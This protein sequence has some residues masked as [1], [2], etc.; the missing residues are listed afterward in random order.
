M[1][2]TEH[3][4]S[5][6]K[7]HPACWRCVQNG[8]KYIT[9]TKWDKSERAFRR[10]LRIAEYLKDRLGEGYVTNGLGYL[11]HCRGN[12]ADALAHFQDAF[13]I[14]TE[15]NDDAMCIAAIGN[16]ANIYLAQ[17]LYDEAIARYQQVIQLDKKIRGYSNQ[18]ISLLN[19][20]ACLI[21]QEKYS[22]A[23]T[24]LLEVLQRIKKSDSPEHADKAHYT[25]DALRLA[26]VHNNLAHIAFEQG[27]Y[28]RGNQYIKIAR[29]LIAEISNQ[30]EE[31]HALLLL[32]KYRKRGNRA[33][34]EE[35]LR[36][37]QEIESD[38]LTRQIHDALVM[39]HSRGKRWQ[40]AL[41][42]STQS[43][44]L[45]KK[46]FSPKANQRL[47][48]LRRKELQDALQT[49][50]KLREDAQRVAN[51]DSLTGLY[52]RRFIDSR[53]AQLFEEAQKNQTD[54][55]V[56][57]LDIDNFKQVN[58]NHSHAVGDTVLRHIAS[59]LSKGLRT[60]DLVGRYGGEEF[61]MILPHTSLVNAN[62]VCERIRQ[63]IERA[64]WAAIS[65]GL[66]VTISAGLCG[67]TSLANQERMLQVADERLYQAKHQGKNV[68]CA[69]AA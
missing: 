39:L 13:A 69:K 1:S 44:L 65:R 19:I 56:V 53:F 15:V 58:D 48:E 37:S 43:H 64:D 54:L 31:V 51:Q 61:I 20:G 50:Q 55:V 36:I 26:V 18:T 12:Q 16:I 6:P 21:A 59:L 9:Q 4:I 22:D 40:L 14:F 28:A 34:L 23:E 41:E 17:E 30:E 46:L 3:A 42:H 32:G 10:G 52:N 11:Q 66:H 38:D 49:A 68:I 67:D 25:P 2:A 62:R 29:K 24:T 35:A 5:N 27:Q 33:Y 47:E 57:L 7:P 45:T 60:T 63:T 8:W